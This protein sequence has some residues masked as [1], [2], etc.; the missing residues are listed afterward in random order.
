MAR[1]KKRAE[2]KKRSERKKTMVAWAKVRGRCNKERTEVI[3]R[4]SLMLPPP[5]QFLTHLAR[6]FFH[7]E[8]D[9]SSCAREW[10]LIASNGAAE[11]FPRGIHGAT[12]WLLGSF[13]AGSACL[14]D[15]VDSETLFDYAQ[16]VASRNVHVRSDGLTLSVSNPMTIAASWLSGAT[17]RLPVA[18]ACVG[19]K[20]N[21]PHT[22]LRPWPPVS[23]GN[24][25]GAPTAAPQAARK[26][27]GPDPRA[28]ASAFPSGRRRV[29]V[30]W[31]GAPGRRLPGNS[32]GDIF[33][34]TVEAASSWRRH[35]LH[36]PCGYGVFPAMATAAA[37]TSSLLL[38]ESYVLVVRSSEQEYYGVDREGQPVYIKRLGKINPNKLMQITTVDC[39]LSLLLCWGHGSEL[40]EIDG[41][42]K[43]SQAR[44]PLTLIVVSMTDAAALC[45]LFKMYEIVLPILA[46][47]G[48]LNPSVTCHFKW[49]WL[50]LTETLAMRKA[51]AS[52]QSLGGIGKV[53]LPS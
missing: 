48:K 8:N 34:E 10:R 28:A 35:Q 43:S 18:G 12:S 50:H 40:M 5:T 45:T 30:G 47:H 53:T 52:F 9:V 23:V 25:V 24:E 13:I 44:L 17:P 39:N 27:E 38:Q 6:G 15:S 4:T 26:A 51:T 29:A 41:D 7:K 42:F 36:L 1:E 33:L 11:L 19:L 32:S 16:P 14:P 31:G 49:V 46:E 21:L 3:D 2:R 20:P 37:A 22:W